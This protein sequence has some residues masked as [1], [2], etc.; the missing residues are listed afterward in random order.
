MISVSKLIK[1]HS[2]P[3]DSL[4]Y[5]G[6]RRKPIVVLNATR[7]CNLKCVHCYAAAGSGPADGEL[8]T[9]EIYALIDD[10]AAYGSPV[11]LLSGGEPLLRPGIERIAD[12]ATQAGLRVAVSSNG[13]LLD[14]KL[15]AAL[16]KAGV[17]YIG[18][19]LD[20]TGEI[21]DRFRGSTGAFDR[22]MAG[23]ER[24]RDAGLRVGL[25]F[26]ITRAN[27][28]E[29]EKILNLTEER[30]IERVCFYH[31]VPAGRASAIADEDLGR[32]ET[33]TVLD[34]IFERARKDTAP[35][36]ILTVDNHSD[37]P[38]LYLYL[39]RRGSER[40]P[41]ALK[42]LRA[43]G[44]NASGEA[45]ACID[46][47]GQVTPDQFWRSAVVGNIREEPFS[48]IWESTSGLLGELKRREELIIGRCAQKNCRWFS[49]CR[50]N[51]RARAEAAGDRWGPDPACVLED[52][53]IEITD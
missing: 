24:A 22:T 30:G 36:E 10:L 29:A 2:E 25:R 45:F 3:G 12:Y 49:V 21:N 4:R 19:S 23:M 48:R 43:N 20:G 9:D 13:T 6:G 52:E 44:G 8:T 17:A 33:R 47:A 7:A 51:M 28:Q 27:V 5:R 46:W 34:M 41:A 16:K 26:T 40:A 11:L 14:D 32:A 1:G 50:G 15:A 37:G 53:E 39:K 18:I 31:L 42:L 38:Y 35:R